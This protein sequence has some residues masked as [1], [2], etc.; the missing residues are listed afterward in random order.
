MNRGVF[1]TDFKFPGQSNFYRGKVRDVY[2]IGES[3]L[4]I[5]ASDRISAFDVVL[6]TP[7][8]YKG[9]VLNQIAS[10]FLM[11]TKQLVPNWL[12]ASPHPY[13]SIGKKCTPFRIEMVVR[14][15]LAGHS[16]REYQAGKRIIC[17]VVMPEGMRE[18]DKF[19]APIITPATKAD[20]G[21]DEDIS[22]EAIIAQG[23]VSK[24][25]YELLEKY[26]LKLFELGSKKAEDRGLLLVDTKYEFGRSEDGEI[27]LIDEIHTP[28]SS[29]YYIAEGYE[30]RQKIMKGKGNFQKNLFA[31]G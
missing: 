12:I 2:S 14:G 10:S 4:V 21:H 31:N 18:A 1:Q 24:E 16:W 9:Q 17:G 27:L 26:T 8:P 13:V 29:R 7:I 3:L 23:I 30:L 11:E 22:R 25:D 6:P 19:P 20:Q 15:Y 5:V 28:D